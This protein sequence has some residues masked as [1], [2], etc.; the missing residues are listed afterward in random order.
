MTM[1]KLSI[2]HSNPVG[3][4]DLGAP[5]SFVPTHGRR[6]NLVMPPAALF[7]FFLLLIRIVNFQLSISIVSALLHNEKALRG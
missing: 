1:G 6:M 3:R 5:Y 7:I 2:V 4:D